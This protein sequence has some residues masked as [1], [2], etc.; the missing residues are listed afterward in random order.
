MSTRGKRLPFESWRKALRLIT[1]PRSNQ[2]A[3]LALANLIEALEDGDPLRILRCKDEILSIPEEV[4]LEKLIEER[5]ALL[6][7]KD[8]HGR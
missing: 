7:P 5:I 2:R 1:S 3:E 8:R 4:L 6:H